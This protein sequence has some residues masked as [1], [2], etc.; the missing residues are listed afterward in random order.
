MCDHKEEMRLRLAIR[1]EQ[2]VFPVFQ[3]GTNSPASD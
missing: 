3:S 2:I 1:A